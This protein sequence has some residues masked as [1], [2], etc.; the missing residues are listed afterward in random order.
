MFRRTQKT[1]M[2]ASEVSILAGIISTLQN[3]LRY[4]ELMESHRASGIAWSKLSRDTCIE[5][6]LDPPRRKPIATF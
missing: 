4:A 1:A 2:A 5:L 3:F 6:A